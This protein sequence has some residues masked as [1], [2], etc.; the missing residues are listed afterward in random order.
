MQFILLLPVS[1]TNGRHVCNLVL[2]ITLGWRSLSIHQVLL[3]VFIQAEVITIYNK[4]NMA[5]AAI[6]ESKKNEKKKRNSEI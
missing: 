4:S 3:N 1:E 5:Y 2:K 6:F